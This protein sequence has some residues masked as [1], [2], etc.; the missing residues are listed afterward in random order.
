MGPICEFHFRNRQCLQHD[1]SLAN[2]TIEGDSLVLLFRFVGFSLVQWCVS[3]LQRIRECRSV[4]VFCFI[5]YIFFSG[6]ID[7]ITSFG[8]IPENSGLN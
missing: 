4:F 7:T 5:F 6:K 8:R 3:F 2:Q 1:G